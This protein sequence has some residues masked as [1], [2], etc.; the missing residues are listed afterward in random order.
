L[1]LCVDTFVNNE[2]C[3]VGGPVI[4]VAGIGAAGHGSDVVGTPPVAVLVVVVV[5]VVA[6]PLEVVVVAGAVVTDVDVDVVGVGG[7][8]DF[9]WLLHAP[10]A[11]QHAAATKIQ[12]TSP[13][14]HRRR[15]E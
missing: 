6:A 10:R 2:L 12:R 11:R 5:V 15:R 9:E 1:S 8:A 4:G 13:S 3:W 14:L 7:L